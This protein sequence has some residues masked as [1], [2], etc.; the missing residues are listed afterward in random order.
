MAPKTDLRAYFKRNAER[1]EGPVGKKQIANPE[2]II[3]A[4]E[5]VSSLENEMVIDEVE[6]STAQ[7]NHYNNVLKHTAV[8]IRRYALDHSTKDALEKFSK[9]YP[10]FTFKRTSINSWKTLLK[11]SGDNQTY[12]KKSR[13]NLLSETLLKKTK[14]GIVGSHLASTIISRRMLIAIGTRVAKANDPG[15]AF[16]SLRSKL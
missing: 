1:S 15:K 13:P 12:N 14:D 6:K 7:K 3:P 9:L 2:M 10:K 5:N 8:E 11:K 16:A 4:T